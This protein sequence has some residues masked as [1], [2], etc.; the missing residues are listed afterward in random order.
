MPGNIFRAG[1]RI[2]NAWPKPHFSNGIIGRS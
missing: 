1:R 2:R